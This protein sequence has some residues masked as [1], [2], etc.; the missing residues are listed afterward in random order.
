[1]AAARD[2]PDDA[3]EPR[4]LLFRDPRSLT[5]PSRR[6]WFHGRRRS[7]PPDGRGASRTGDTGS[8]AHKRTA[9]CWVP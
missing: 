8:G 2:C 1:M 3:A 5:T 9:C 7:T 6:L 4:R